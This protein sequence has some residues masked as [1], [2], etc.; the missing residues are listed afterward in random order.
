MKISSQ[1]FFSTLSK[2][3]KDVSCQTLDDDPYKFAK[4]DMIAGSARYAD[5][6]TSS[7]GR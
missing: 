3:N 7:L 6:E 1:D 4:V 2:S 5:G